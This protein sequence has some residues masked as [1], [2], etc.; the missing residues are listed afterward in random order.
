M[1]TPRHGRQKASGRKGWMILA[2]IL[3]LVLTLVCVALAFGIATNRITWDTR[4]LSEPTDI[5]TTSGTRTPSKRPGASS[6]TAA[7]VSH[8]KQSKAKEWSL[9]LVNSWNTLP[10]GYEKATT[11]ADYDEQGNQIDARV[12]E[13]LDQMMSDGEEY[14]LWG[15]L[16]YRDGETQQTF[17]DAAV[18]K[19]KD[20]GYADSEA[21][22]MAATEVIRPGTSE[23]QTGLALDILGSGYTERKESF[24]Q[25]K[26][27]EWLK[28]H[29]AEYGFILRYPK[30][31]EDITGMEYE[32]WHYRYVGK[33][34]AGEIMSRGITLEEFL[35]EKGW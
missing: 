29:C 10:D 8:Y 22:A 6:T 34:Y 14:G 27:F 13:A 9:L 33:E 5:S 28:A 31:K 1:S 7:G 35:Q 18:K 2:L 11:Y 25:S 21:Q 4:P 20:K 15:I 12:K 16:L 23:H 30:G 19:W 26:A 32:P 3:L 24:D 17:F